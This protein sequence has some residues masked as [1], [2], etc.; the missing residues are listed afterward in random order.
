[1]LKAIFRWNRF[2]RMRDFQ[3]QIAGGDADSL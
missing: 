2:E 3:A 1:M